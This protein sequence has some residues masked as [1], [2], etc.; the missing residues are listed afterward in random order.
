[1]TKRLSRRWWLKNM[2]AGAGLAGASR[3]FPAPFVLAEAAPNSKLA[4]AV[5]GCG[6]R[7]EASL[8]AAVG[9][10]LVAIVDV[11]ESRIAA[12]AKRASA[13]GVRSQTFFDYRRMFNTMH[14]EIDAVFVATP[15]HHHAPASMRAIQLGKHVFCEKP[16]CH[17]IWQARAL[18]QAAQRHKVVTIMGNQAIKAGVGAKVE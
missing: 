10:K 18:A 16:L 2:V 9:E 4:V 3:L 1:M 11:D 12:A 8:A 7:G 14:R 15:D 5:I 6:G 13:S 17:D